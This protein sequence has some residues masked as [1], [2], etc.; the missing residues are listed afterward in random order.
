MF[1]RL[2]I[3]ISAVILEQGTD[4]HAIKQKNQSNEIT[5]LMKRFTSSVPPQ[6]LSSNLIV[7]FNDRQFGSTN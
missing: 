1:P 3:K 7:M 2:N 5:Q 6:T 4:L